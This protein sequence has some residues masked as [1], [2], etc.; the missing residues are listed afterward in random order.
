MRTRLWLSLLV[1]AGVA[2]CSDSP[3]GGTTPPGADAA[4]DVAPDAKPDVA[5]PDAT[6]DATPDAAPDATPDAAP[7]AAPDATPAC[8]MGQSMCGATC[9][10]TMTDTANCGM[11]GTTCMAGQAC[12][13]GSCQCRTGTAACGGA[14]VDTQTDT[15]NCGTCGNACPMGRSCVA[16]ACACLMGRTDCSG[17]CID[18]QADER[19]CGGCGRACPSGQSCVMG[20]CA[21]PT[22]QTLCGGA[23]VDVQT[24]TANCG[25]CGN[26]CP[27]SQSCAAGACACPTGRTACGTGASLACVDV[28]T[29][30][31]NCGACGTACAMGQSCTAGA[32]ACPTGQ[33]VCGSGA[34]A[35]CVNT[36]TANA[37]CGMCGN[38]C[39]TA[40]TCAGG[41]CTCPTGQTACGT[42]CVNVQ[43]DSANC[44]ACGR[45]CPAAQSCVAG[46]CACPTGQTACGTGTALT[47]ANLQTSTTNCGAC[48]RA[49]AAGQS[50]VAGLCGTV[51]AN[52]TRDGAAVIPLTTPQ[53]TLTADTTGAM[54]NTTGPSDCNCTSGRD[55]FY[56]FTLAQDE[57]VYADTFDGETWDSSLILQDAMGNNLTPGAGDTTCNDDACATR[58]SQVSA[59]LA[60]GRYFLVV[61][62]CSQGAVTVRF[63]HLVVGSGGA[64]RVAAPVTGTQTVTGTLAP[65]ASRVNGGC[66]SD[67]PENLYFFATCPSF[68]SQ[69]LHLTTC[70]GADWDTVLHQHSPSRTPV[71]VCNDDF[72]GLQSSLDAP[73]PAGAGL[74]GW[75]LDVYGSRAPGAF[76]MRYAFG[77]CSTG[78]TGCGTPS[79]CR[80]TAGDNGN[81]GA[82]DRVCSGGQSCA[83]GTCTCPTGQTFCGSGAAAACVDLQSSNANCGACG[84]ACVN[85]STCNAGACTYTTSTRDVTVAGTQTVNA[86][87]ASANGAA[88]ADRVTITNVVGTFAAGD[89]VLLHQTQ[90]ASGAVGYS[91]LRRVT[92]VIAGTPVTLVFDA[93]LTNA[94]ATS[95]SPF[96]RAQVVR[97]E[98]VRNLTVPTG[99]TLNAPT[100]NGT[101]GGVLAVVA[102]ASVT[103]AGTVNMDG[104]G[105]RGRGHPCTYRCARGYQGEG[106]AG[107]GGADIAANG[108][109]G[110]GGGAGQDDGSGGGGGYAAAGGAGGNGTCGTCRE[111]CPIPGGNGGALAG[112]ANLATAFFLGGAGGEGG[113][114]E[115]GSNPG[116]GGN[117]GGA[118][119]IRASTFNVTGSIVARGAAGAGGNQNSCGGVGC[120]MGGGGG[121]AG[122]AIRLQASGTAV[123]GTNLLNVNGA[124]G[125]GATC[126]SATGGAGSV[127]RIGVNA[128]TVTGATTP[129]LDRN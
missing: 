91:E 113:A 96:A 83:A 93:S 64:T 109:G 37:N 17:T 123:I 39:G 125:G 22:G 102:G 128:P 107:L 36:M 38:A 119:F 15:N 115:D 48:G 44:G 76:T 104:R 35:A 2:A 118:V 14:C 24:S 30:T 57:V 55:V 117:G 47:C 81:C 110:G 40:Q 111:A 103:V 90:R 62:G 54:N 51:P 6:P 60:A 34:A 28:Q 85:G 4:P 108:N 94:Y 21:C 50:C 61:S 27:A 49:C 63:Q 74:H 98:E 41:A 86:V 105:F 16:G 69:T 12:V 80:Y 32:C 26:A 9:I 72:C 45:A 10:D 77:A 89:L 18:T 59:R 121:G 84:N 97:V 82:C 31:A 114:D 52:D 78:F 3:P 129:A 127:G 120:G 7:D 65:G 106:V 67:G 70:G 101:T 88:G 71:T 29:D 20:A 58:R 116:A 68:A 5:Q 56:T 75:Y 99:T 42:S 126:G 8:P 11:C 33:T 112:T 79:A 43:T 100:W 92:S 25:T 46:A 95:D 19:H 122:G 124:G 23:C 13:A 1:A 73:L 66:T 87:A 53:T